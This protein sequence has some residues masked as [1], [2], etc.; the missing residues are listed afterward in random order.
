MPTRRSFIVALA[1]TAIAAPALAA[2]KSAEAF[3]AG[4]YANYKGKNAKGQSFDTTA[5][6]NRLFTP[7]LAKLIDADSKTA[8]KRSEVGA[9]GGD[10]FVDAQDFEIEGLTID[11]KESGPGKATGTV[12]FKN[13]GKDTTIMLDLVKLP[14]GWRI[15]E[16]RMPSGSLRSLFK[17]A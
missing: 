1:L 8:A 7:S 12:K 9:L 6:I 15:D 2:D 3:L 13:F 17:K 16:I 14:Q 10:P 4:I 11:V 5:K